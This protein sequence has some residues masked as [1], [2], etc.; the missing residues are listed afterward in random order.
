MNP[1]VWKIMKPII[2]FF[3]IGLFSGIVLVL[4]VVS[5]AAR[6]AGNANA[7]LKCV[8]EGTM[9]LPAGRKFVS[10][11]HCGNG[12]TLDVITRAMK[13][14]EGAESYH[15]QLWNPSAPMSKPLTITESVLPPPN[16]MDYGGY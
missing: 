3:G 13:P 5:D 16:G 10:V 7:Q 9:W 4:G 8:F 14:G 2:L 1:C 11:G 6:R 12:A 15:F